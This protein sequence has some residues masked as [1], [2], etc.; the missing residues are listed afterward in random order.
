MMPLEN[1][2][3]I[4]QDGD[5]FNVSLKS[6]ENYTIA[7]LCEAIEKMSQAEAKEAS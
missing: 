7:D 5:Y 1:I 3:S 4:S 6:A 2:I